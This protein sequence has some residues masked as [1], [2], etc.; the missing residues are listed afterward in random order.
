MARRVAIGNN[1]GGVGKSTTTVRLAEALARA[2]KRVLVVDMDPQGNASRRLGWKFNPEEPQLTISEA[3][4]ADET[5]VAGQVVQPIGWTGYFTDRIVLCPARLDLENRMSEAGVVGAHR[6]LAKA[7]DGADDHVD[8]TLIDCPPSLFHL[9][10]LA[11]AAADYGL[12][13]TEPEYDAVE[14][15]VRYKDFIRERAADLSNPDL[16]LIG[17]IVSGHDGRRGGH[18]FQLEGIPD[19]FPG[20]M[21]E[22]VVPSRAVIMDADEAALPLTEM[23]GSAADEARQAYAD[24]AKHFIKAVAA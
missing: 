12:A 20:L 9:T 21:W 13:V 18:A 10:Q 19:L 5:G 22:P 23:K 7:L 8:Y 2:G 14:A 24:L 15:A 4:K 3:I 17:V 1:K 6:R 16:E 11:M